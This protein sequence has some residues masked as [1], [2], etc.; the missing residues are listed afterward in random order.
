[1]SKN[2]K[3]KKSLTV[4]VV[5][6][7]V[8]LGL[9]I[10]AGCCG[11]GYL[12]YTEVLE[13]MYNDKAYDIAYTAAELLD[14]DAIE[15]WQKDL[16]E[17]KNDSEAYAQLGLE[18][19]KDEKY[20][21]VEDKLTLLRAKM[22]ANYIYVADMRGADGKVIDTLTYMFDADNPD[23]PYPPFLP[24]EQGKM[25]AAFLTDA[26]AIYDT[27]ERS[28]NYFYSHSA[29]GYNTSAIIPIYNSNGSKVGIIGVELTM[30]TLMQA[31]REYLLS[32]ALLSLVVMLVAVIIYVIVVRKQII[33]PIDVINEETGRF[34]EDEA[35]VSEKL[36]AVRGN[37]E[38]KSLADGIL[39]MEIKT[40]AYI[41]NIT[42]ITA[43]KER[44]GAELDVARN[45]QSS[46]LPCIFPSY[47]DNVYYDIYATMNPAKEVGG[48]FYD[49]FM[50]DES[51]LAIVVADVSGKGVPAALFMVIGK[52]LIKDH[53]T[54]GADLGQVFAEV[55][56]LLCESNSEGLFI[57]AFEG[58][59]DL[60]TGRFD[61]VNAGHEIPFGFRKGDR[62]KPYKVKSG[63]V[64]A[65]MENTKFTAGSIMMEPGDKIFQYTDGVT[66]A[67]NV[68]NELYGMERLE[69]ILN[70]NADAAPE[71][72]LP[73]IKKDID[74]FVG[75]APQFDDITMLCLTY[76]KRME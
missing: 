70:A 30:S 57:T 18:I 65:G 60:R 16:D 68:S 61:F 54:P 66:E 33:H 31:R 55:N 3:S 1:M 28:S 5:V 36:G 51:H 10:T 43:E 2:G 71:E 22:E 72:L 8:I 63:F 76:K 62:F 73:V 39:Q 27:G 45:I 35:Q 69:K 49:F 17:V 44:I 56:K 7:C 40:R 11:V 12:R 4:L 42:S 47:P 24:G 59:L 48:D 25:N 34:I 64:L 75:D 41:D 50:V 9:L 32:T 58:V 26:Q 21:S 74:A 15:A 37:G 6:C 53:T 67:T 46:M 14:G 38:I 19:S 52:T 23:D 20:A 13:K 29:F